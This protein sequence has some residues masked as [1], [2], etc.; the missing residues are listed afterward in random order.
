MFSSEYSAARADGIKQDFED[1]D[2]Y[3]AEE[4]TLTPV[5]A[6]EEAMKNEPAKDSKDYC[7]TQMD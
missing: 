2:E 7:R 1:R 5:S 3:V 4:V 6:E